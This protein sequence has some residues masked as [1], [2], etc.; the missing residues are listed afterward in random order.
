MEHLSNDHKDHP[1]QQENGHKLY[2][3]MGHP[4]SSL[5]EGQLSWAM[6]SACKEH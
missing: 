2:E 3:E 6:K 1:N 5:L 4:I